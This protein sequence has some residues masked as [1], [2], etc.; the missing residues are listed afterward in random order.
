MTTKA[1]ILFWLVILIINVQ[2]TI[3]AQKVVL[4]KSELQ[5]DLTYLKKELENYHPNLF[6][7]S[8]P[9]TVTEWFEKTAIE[10]SDSLPKHE[11]F[12]VISSFSNV[13]KDGHSYIYPSEDHLSQ[14]FASAPLFPLAIFLM[15]QGYR[16]IGNFSKEQ[17]IPI[18]AKLVRI[19]G[20]PMDTIQ[21]VIVTNI[22]RD[23]DNYAYP[24]YLFQEFFPAYYSYFYGFQKIYQVTY[25]DQEGE[26]QNTLIH[27]R[28]NKEIRQYKKK[29]NYDQKQ[30][31][32]IEVEE[33]NKLAILNIPSFD[34]SVLKKEY[35]QKFKKEIKKAFRLIEEKQIEHLA[36]DLRDNQGGALSNGI[37][38][39]RFIM[40]NA[41]QSIYATSKLDQNKQ[42]IRPLKRLNSR[43]D[44][45]FKPK[46]KNHFGGNVYIFIN[47]GSFSC[48]AIVA[49][50]IKENKN[51]VI[52]GEMTGGSAYINSGGP[53]KLITL[54]NS[55]ILFTIPKIRYQLRKGL[56]TIG[57]G[58]TPNVKVVASSTRYKEEID[59]YFE[60]LK[61]L[62]SKSK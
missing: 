32:G 43:S 14:Y 50:T 3:I 28:T 19:N 62:I 53:N 18:G 38:L 40:K 27:G 23:G 39:L 30:G 48:S 31:I 51:G 36:I 37:F 7:Y 44:N 57:L 17:N 22:S 15:E 47:G 12:K 41:F 58:V 16:I 54:P 33:T 46:K 8:S 42:G 56:D 2:P 20:I 35:Q 24:M 61:I 4:S 26:L 60:I 13:L 6:V 52:L 45:F 49:N 9:K 55:R 21:R 11:A 25:L 29:N 10:L 5:E 34:K 59:P 1:Q